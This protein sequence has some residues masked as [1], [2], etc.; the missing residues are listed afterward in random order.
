LLKLESKAEK[1]KKKDKKVVKNNIPKTQVAAN[2][3]GKKV[4][5]EVVAKKSKDVAVKGPDKS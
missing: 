5:T 4:S 1:N 3:N 2:V